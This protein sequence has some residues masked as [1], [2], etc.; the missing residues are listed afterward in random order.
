MGVPLMK[1]KPPAA[2]PDLDAQGLV[3][4]ADRYARRLQAFYNTRA[5]WH[6]RFYRLGGAVVILTG[7]GLPLLATLDYAGKA[8]VVSLAGTALSVLSGLHAFYRW[9]Q[10]WVLLRRTEHK[11]TSAYWEWRTALPSDGDADG[12]STRLTREFLGTLAVIRVDEARSFFDKLPSPTAGASRQS[13]Q[14]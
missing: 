7:A 13:L 1:F 4:A 5:I 6:R 11:I 10:S 12:E 8:L 9:D 14:Q 2:L 3:D